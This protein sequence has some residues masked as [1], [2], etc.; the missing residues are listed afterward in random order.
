MFSRNALIAAGTIISVGIVAYAYYVTNDG[1]DEVKKEEAD[2]VKEDNEKLKENA[3]DTEDADD[4]E[5][6]AEEGGEDADELEEDITGLEREGL[7][8]IKKGIDEVAR[9]DIDELKED[10]YELEEDVTGLEQED[11]TGLKEGIDEVAQEDIDELVVN[12]IVMDL[13][14]KFIVEFQNP[15]ELH[16]ITVEDIPVNLQDV[17]DQKDVQVQDVRVNANGIKYQVM[18]LVPNLLKLFLFSLL[19]WLVTMQ[20]GQVDGSLQM[21]M[22]PPPPAQRH[23]VLE[24]Y[25]ELEVMEIEIVTTKVVYSP[26]RFKAVVSNLKID[27]LDMQES[28]VHSKKQFENKISV[29]TKNYFGFFGDF[30][31]TFFGGVRKLFVW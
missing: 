21:L 4:L 11:I 30:F 10:V 17:V 16:D 3:D 25:E 15:T 27:E 2:E 6:A 7:T 12:A 31:S 20:F 8:G 18:I 9:E 5:E 22:L 28:P 23:V 29:K 24:E 1:D 26:E 13:D 14:E 19:V